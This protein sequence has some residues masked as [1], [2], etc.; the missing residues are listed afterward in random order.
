MAK[1][2]PDERT[3]VELP[4]VGQLEAMGWSRLEGDVDVPYLTER[5]NFRE[6]LLKNRLK[7]ALRRINRDEQGHEWL[8]ERRANLAIGALERLEAH[9]LMEANQQ[10]T[11][12]LLQG[13][14]V[15]GDPQREGGRAQTGW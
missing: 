5:E 7:A 13:A 3:K 1:P 9:K 15:E 14:V 8:D 4:L 10:A 6:V 12:L 11:A 2:L